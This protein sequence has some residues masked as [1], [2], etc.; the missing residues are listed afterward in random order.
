[1]TRAS[2]CR[3]DYVMVGNSVAAVAAVEAIREVDGAGSILVLGEEGVPAYSR[4]L[5]SEFFAGRRDIADMVYPR[6]GFYE[7]MDATVRT[8][9]KVV[10]CDIR[11][12]T[13]TT[14]A[15]E[16]IAYRALLLATGSRAGMPRIEGLNLEGV[17]TLTSIEDSQGIKEYL[18]RVRRAC[19]I[20]GGL[21][22]LQAAEALMG[23]GRQVVV[24]EFLDRVLARVFDS[25]GSSL[26]ADLFTSRG[27]TI[28][29]G[30]ATRALRAGDADP[31]RVAEVVLADG[32]RI[33]ADMVI[34]ATGVVPRRELAESAGMDTAAGILVDRFMRTSAPGV[35]AAGD[36]AEAHE[37]LTGTRRV[38]PLWPNAYLQGRVAGLNMAGQDTPFPGGLAMN[39][40]HFFGFPAMSA[41]MFDPPAEDGYEVLQEYR[42]G[43]RFYRK[44]VLKDGRLVGF[45]SAG[46]AV[47]RSGVILGLI[48]A[49]ADVSGCEGAIL[50][51]PGLV[52]LPEP[53]R[54]RMLRGAVGVLE[55]GSVESPGTERAQEE[56]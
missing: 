43:E 14:A 19:V 54:R 25:T 26:I 18:P 11:A 32:T 12:G 53:L 38:V 28:L 27:A 46:D 48:R 39:S 24:V 3:Y 8:S 17:F 56:A 30:V 33:P 15:G 21:I 16:R 23:L 2:E 36:V 7:D 47:D 22:G 34:V 31:T 35:F 49:G 13:V 6:P 9:T 50:K 41:G 4:P 45:V 55:Q 52:A 29:T 51:C 5:I 44:L 37:L 42:P 1:M 10:A 40:S 20:G